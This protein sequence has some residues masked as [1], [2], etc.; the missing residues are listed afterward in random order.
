MFEPL[1]PFEQNL[2]SSMNAVPH[3]QGFTDFQTFATGKVLQLDGMLRTI[4]V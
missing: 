3:C 4:S 1:P 2:Y